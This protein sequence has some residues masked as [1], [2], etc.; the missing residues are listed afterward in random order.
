MLKT[1]QQHLRELDRER[2]IDSYLYRVRRDILDYYRDEESEAHYKTIRQEREHAEEFYGAYLD[3][4]RL[5]KI[6][7]PDGKHGLFYAFKTISDLS[8]CKS[9]PCFPYVNLE[10]VIEQGEEATNYGYDLDP[11]SEI[12]GYF[13][14][15]DEYT[16]QNIYELMADVMFEA[17]W[18]GFADESK[19]DFV[20][21]LADK[22]NRLEGG[23]LETCP[24][25]DIFPDWYKEMKAQEEQQKIEEAAERSE[26]KND[27]EE[28]L[29]AQSVCEE[30]LKLIG[31]YNDR[32]NRRQKRLI[33]RR[34]LL[35]R[36]IGLIQC[37][38]ECKQ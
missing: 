16:Q 15:D 5:L 24:V 33:Q 28:E 20:D 32:A 8:K 14:S 19:D 38:G 12:M 9:E 2:L 31:D 29:D 10:D 25:D 22:I 3:R 35:A 6:T 17:S 18:F 23:T 34:L 36:L 1:V 7:P 30:A 26:V 13:V 11:Q 27:D 21:D 4:L 37:K